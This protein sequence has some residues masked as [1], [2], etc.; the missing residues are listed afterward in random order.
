MPVAILFVICM[1]LAVYVADKWTWKKTKR[2]MEKLFILG[3]AIVKSSLPLSQELWIGFKKSF[4]YLRKS[5]G[6]FFL[7]VS[8]EVRQNELNNENA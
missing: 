6:R 2:G 5:I 4:I 1:G 7:K 8:E 3:K